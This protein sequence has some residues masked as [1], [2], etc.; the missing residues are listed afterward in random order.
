MDLESNI[1]LEIK[2][3]VEREEDSLLKTIAFY[4]TVT[5]LMNT[6]VHHRFLLWNYRACKS[7]EIARILGRALNILDRYIIKQKLVKCFHLLIALH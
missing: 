2:I 5:R 4:D 3:T 6:S 7:G 1:E